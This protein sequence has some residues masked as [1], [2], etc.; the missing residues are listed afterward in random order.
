MTVLTNRSTFARGE[1]IVSP[2][3]SEQSLDVR[4]AFAKGVY[5]RVFVWI[6]GKINQA[7]YKPTVCVMKNYFPFQRSYR[8]FM[9][10]ILIKIT[11]RAN[12]Y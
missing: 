1:V 9:M 12:Y 11:H 6:V 10:D 5:G 8:N 7:V 4:D 3:R 2:I